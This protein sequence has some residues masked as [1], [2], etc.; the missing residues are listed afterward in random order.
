[1]RKF[2]FRSADI[3]Q[4]TKLLTWPVE[5]LTVAAR[6]HT[7]RKRYMFDPEGGVCIVLARL[8]TAGRWPE[9]E[10]MFFASAGACCEIFYFVV[11]I[12]FS[13]FSLRISH[14]LDMLRRGVWADRACRT[15]RQGNER[16][17]EVP[18]REAGWRAG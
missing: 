17:N 6:V 9:M 10:Q 15:G 18:H 3:S 2:R 5:C 7:Q 8:S 4:M 12:V 13:Q 16:D 11:S 14:P 1:V